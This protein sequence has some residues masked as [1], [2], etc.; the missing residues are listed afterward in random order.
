[1]NIWNLSRNTKEEKYFENQRQ[2]IFILNY[3]QKS[4]KNF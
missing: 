4:N 3:F 1:M 2:S